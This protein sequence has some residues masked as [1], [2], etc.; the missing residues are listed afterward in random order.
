[1]TYSEFA[2]DRQQVVGGPD[3]EASKTAF[4]ST[5]VSRPEFVQKF[6]ANTS[7]ESFVD[8]LLQTVRNSAGVDLAGERPNLIARYN[9]SN[10]ATESRAA[11]LSELGGNPAL[12]QAVYNPSFVLME[13]FGYLRR[14]AEPEGYAFWLNVIS[15]DGASSRGMVCSFL[16]SAEY[17]RRFGSVVTRSNAD[18]GR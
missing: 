1:M 7:A 5:F 4:T 9:S 16:T 2:T 15:R 14:G 11:V 12:G 17:Q 8:A 13:Y 18:C 3:L 10:S 6:Q